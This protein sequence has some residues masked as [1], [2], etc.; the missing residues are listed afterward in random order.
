MNAQ[1][2]RPRASLFFFDGWISISASVMGTA[3]ELQ[4]R[5]YDVDLFFN[6]PAGDLAPPQFPNG[7]TPYEYMPWTR[8]I[9]RSLIGRLR[10]RKLEQL[11]K[12]KADDSIRK[13]SAML[14]AIA[15]AFIGLIEIPQFALH[16]RTHVRPTDLAVA[17]DMNSLVAMDLALS[18]RVP[19]IYWSLEIWRLADLRDPFSRLMKRHELRR[20]P[21]AR[22][23]VAQSSV[24]RAIIED[25]L[26]EP[27]RNYIE[28]PNAPSHPM[29]ATLRRDF[30]SSRFPIPSD[31]WIVL[32]SGFISTSLMS[33]E[34]AQTVR[35]WHS[36]FVLI[37]HE[38]QKRDRQEPY[39]QAVQDA[40]GDRTFM[41]L[42]PVPYS[43]V[44]NVYAGADI[45]LV[46]YQT[47][48]LNEATAWASSGKLVYYLRH[49][50]PI[51]IVMPE[52]PSILEEWRCGVWIAD[53]SEIGAALIRIAAD[54]EF[55]SDRARQAY[56]AMFDFS[57]AF[58][59]LMKIVKLG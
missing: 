6:S 30:Y 55:Y 37:F 23:V 7:I 5:G 19:F 57:A 27:L 32:H 14:R 8:K 36:D 59:R 47:A 2:R 58:D 20:L 41:S 46:C 4:A 34:I 17:F 49:G 40:G 33:Q 29:P 48:E 18:R 12:V 53:V 10:R 45:G 11:S 22:A 15:K 42:E 31:G 39:I 35:T 43:E 3:T 44:D 1:D 13:K 21:E 24:R 50:M 38:R 25:D 52:C 56:A 26:P 28:V 54:Y 16:C 9:T 51:I